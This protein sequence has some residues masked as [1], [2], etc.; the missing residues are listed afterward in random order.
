MSPRGTFWG[1]LFVGL[2]SLGVVLWA[3]FWRPHGS[4]SGVDLVSTDTKR[5]DRKKPHSWRSLND[6]SHADSKNSVGT[7]LKLEASLEHNVQVLLTLL[8]SGRETDFLNQLEKII[9]ENPK[10]PEYWA[11]RADYFHSVRNWEAAETAYEKVVELDPGNQHAKVALGE[12]NAIRGKLDE[13]HARMAEVL[14]V[15]PSHLEA[16]QGYLSISEMQGRRSVGE[17][18]VFNLYQR[19]PESAA[20][21]MVVSDIYASRSDWSLREQ[22]LLKAIESEPSHPGPYR[23]LAVE[24]LRKGSYKRA[25]KFAEDSLSREKEQ[26]FRHMTLDVLTEAAIKARDVKAADKYLALKKRENPFDL[27]LQEQERALVELKQQ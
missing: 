18:F 14:S 6:V 26:E 23:L 10:V 19:H 22:T 9:Q 12:V 7:E 3:M 11:F 2:L 20:I 5:L 13:A 4:E 8:E 16:L 21:A 25:L 1:L 15:D 17:D 27:S 24:S